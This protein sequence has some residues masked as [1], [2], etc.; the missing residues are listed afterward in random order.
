MGASKYEIIE[1]K[2]VD[3]ET[4]E[5]IENDKIDEDI[6]ATLVEIG[7][8]VRNPRQ[9]E[10]LKKQQKRREDTTPFIW[11]NY[12]YNQPFYPNM[13]DANITRMILFSTFCNDKGYVMTNQD[14]RPMLK[15]NANQLK[16][17]RDDLYAY[18]ILSAKNDKLYI[19]QNA[20]SI[21]ERI[22][23]NNAF[24]RVFLDSNRKLYESCKITEH[25]KLSYIYKMIP[26]VNRQTNILSC[27][28]KEQELERIEYMPV[29]EFCN[30]VGYNT[31][32]ISRFRTGLSKFRIYD[33]LAVGFFD[34]I[35]ELN[36]KGKYVVVNPKL[37]Y[38][39]DRSI[40]TYKT[41]C[42][43]FQAEKKLFLEKD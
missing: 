30:I 38:G 28:Q 37:F 13:Q 1:Y 33:E 17:F 11:A 24:I 14:I 9:I 19:N 42:K 4:G 6:R 26:Y 23:D 22:E 18:D 25:K 40:Q 43:L 15:I 29:K 31:T 5:I 12:G 32:H 35:S 16:S 20:F 41:I 7:G 3:K 10:F 36:P 2:V 27:N 39:G 21:G 34:N 8:Y